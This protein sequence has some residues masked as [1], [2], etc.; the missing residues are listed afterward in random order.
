MA[1]RPPTD[2]APDVHAVTASRLRA[3]GHTY[4]SR[5]RDLVAILA[6]APQP[7]SIPEV[8]ERDKRLA[9][10]SVYRNLALLEQAGVV[11][12][13]VTKDEFARFELSEEL[14]GHHH[15]HL[16][17]SGCGA[18]ED[19]TLPSSVEKRVGQELEKLA[20]EHGFAATGHQMDLVGL[21]ARCQ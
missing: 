18:V 21:C 3:L 9:Q 17:C 13:I 11:H 5:R 12:R 2:H 16:I 20:Q 15:H 7:L 1:G 6:D 10:S 19:V 4:P 8:L 14:S